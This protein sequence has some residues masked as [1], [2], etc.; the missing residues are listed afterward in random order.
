MK[1]IHTA[2]P[3]LPIFLI[4][5]SICF[6][7]PVITNQPA[8]QATAPG[9]TVTPQVRASSIEPLAYQWQKNP[10]NGCLDLADRTNA[11]LLLVNGQ[12]WDASDYRVVVTNITGART[13]AVARH[14][15][16]RPALVTTN[17]VIDNVDDNRL[18]GW[19]SDGHKG[20]ATLTETNQQFKV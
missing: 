4:A 1:T 12:P 16:M 18:T 8:P 15:L 20:Q 19:S 10:G 11:A 17:V 5:V 13:S 9:T 14:Y 7:Q 6:G 3:T 2:G